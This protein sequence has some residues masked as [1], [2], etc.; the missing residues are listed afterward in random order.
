EINDEGTNTLI[1]DFIVEQE[2][3]LWMLKSYLNE[4]I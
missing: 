4:A 1:S 2:K 3:N